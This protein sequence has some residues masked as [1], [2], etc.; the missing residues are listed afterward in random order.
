MKEKEQK[1][2]KEPNERWLHR[3]S[4]REYGFTGSCYKKSG[5]I[6]PTAHITLACNGVCRRMKLWDNKNGYRGVT[7]EIRDPE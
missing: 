7:F 4:C 3:V 5:M 2:M 6:S 1:T